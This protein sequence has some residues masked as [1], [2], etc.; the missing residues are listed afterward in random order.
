MMVFLLFLVT[1]LC[2]RAMSFSDV[3]LHQRSSEGAKIEPEMQQSVSCILIPLTFQSLTSIGQT[4]VICF[5]HCKIKR[6]QRDGSFTTI[7]PICASPNAHI[8]FVSLVFS[9]FSHELL[10]YYFV[11]LLLLKP[12][13]FCILQCLIQMFQL[14]LFY[15]AD[16][17]HMHLFKTLATM[18]PA[19]V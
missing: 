11:Q 12:R 16:M 5:E 10:L 18:S 9:S 13:S 8:Y 2:Y 14:R 15:C 1:H 4:L 3:A 6:L 19:V 7:Q 17:F